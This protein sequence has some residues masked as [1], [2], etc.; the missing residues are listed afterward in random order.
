M[1]S[2]HDKR[3]K[4]QSI[5]R[6]WDYSEII[7]WMEVEYKD[8]KFKMIKY[9]LNV[10]F[11]AIKR[12]LKDLFTNR[13][14]GEEEREIIQTKKALEH[15]EIHTYNNTGLIDPKYKN[16]VDGL[17]IYVERL[18][19]CDNTYVQPLWKGL[20]EIKSDSEFVR[21]V[22]YFLESLWD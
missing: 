6:G 5:F 12:A 19:L 3:N 15:L 22:K 9:R 2:L 1:R 14:M 4:T 18:A 7:E 21:Y 8:S 11:K 10:F 16:K 13:F 17:R 20:S